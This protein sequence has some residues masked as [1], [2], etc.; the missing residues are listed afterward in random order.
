MLRWH[1]FLECALSEDGLQATF[2]VQAFDD[3]MTDLV[4]TVMDS[5]T[6]LHGNTLVVSSSDPV[7]S[8]RSIRPPG[9]SCG[10]VI[11]S[12]QDRHD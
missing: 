11:V 3:S 5:V 6:D 7:L 8:T 9:R 10:D 12:D 1:R 4:V 2:E